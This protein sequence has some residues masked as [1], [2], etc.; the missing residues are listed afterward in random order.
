MGILHTRILRDELRSCKESNENIITA[1]E[2][3]K[4]VNAL[5]LWFSSELQEKATR[6]QHQ[7]S[8]KHKSK[9]NP[10]KIQNFWLEVKRVEGRKSKKRPTQESEDT[11]RGDS[12]L[13]TLERRANKNA[14]FSNARNIGRHQQRRSEMSSMSQELKKEKPH[15]FD[16]KSSKI[17]GAEAWMFGIN[18]YFR[19]HE[20]S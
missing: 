7:L 10:S 16:G 2:R 11:V 8:R 3:Q 14:N 13:N 1:Q 5:I 20:Y 9:Q 19:A 18:K 17:E 15:T 6:Y 4:E 12:P